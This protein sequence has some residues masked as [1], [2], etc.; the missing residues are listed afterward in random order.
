MVSARLVPNFP[1][2]SGCATT[3]LSGPIGFVP[4]GLLNIVT[5]SPGANAVFARLAEFAIARAE[6]FWKKLA[7]NSFCESIVS[8]AGFG[9]PARSLVH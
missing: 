3:K 5:I 1:L 4:A 7:P 6:G 9:C 8:V 2:A